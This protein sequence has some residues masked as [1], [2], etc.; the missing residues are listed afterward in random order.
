MLSFTLTLLYLTQLF[1]FTRA[2]YF[3]APQ[4]STVW[5]TPQGQLITWYHQAGDALVGDILLQNV[6]E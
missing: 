3:T 4:A 6:A 5:S 2:L 1:T